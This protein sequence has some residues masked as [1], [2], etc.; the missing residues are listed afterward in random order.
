LRPSLSQ[1]FFIL[2]PHKSLFCRAI[3]V[4]ASH[5]ANDLHF[6]HF[7][8]EWEQFEGHHGNASTWREM[9]R[10]HRSVA[11]SFAAVHF[12]TTNVEAAVPVDASAAGRERDPMVAL[13]AAA[14]ATTAVPIAGF[15]AGGVQ[16]GEAAEGA[17]AGAAPNQAAA[18]PEEI[19]LGDDEV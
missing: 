14:A 15:V 4:F 11:A 5:L 8:Q 17:A 2:P 18:N 16:G 6:P 3:F 13:E 9:M 10:V 12:N 1:F 7:W 19:D